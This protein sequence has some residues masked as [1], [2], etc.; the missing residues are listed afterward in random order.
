MQTRLHPLALARATLLRVMTL[1]L[2]QLPSPRRLAYA[3][4]RIWR[5]RQRRREI[6]APVASSANVVRMLVA[7]GLLS[8]TQTSDRVEVGVAVATLLEQLAGIDA[9]VVAEVLTHGGRM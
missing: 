7:L 6:V 8:E 4:H 9:K 3:R 2:D 5:K 1:Q